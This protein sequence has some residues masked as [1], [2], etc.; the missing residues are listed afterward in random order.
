MTTTEKEAAAVVTSY[1]P[2]ILWLPALRA[3]FKINLIVLA[4]QITDKTSMQDLRSK[5]T[6]N[7]HIAGIFDTLLNPNE[8]LFFAYNYLQRYGAGT[9]K[10]IVTQ[11]DHPNRMNRWYINAL[12]GEINKLKDLGVITYH[13]LEFRPIRGIL[14][15]AP[16][17]TEAQI[18]AAKTKALEL[19]I[20]PEERIEEKTHQELEPKRRVM[21]GLKEYSKD[22]KQVARIQQVQRYDCTVCKFS[23]HAVKMPD[24]CS[25]CRNR[26]HG[27][28][29]LVPADQDVPLRSSMIKNKE[30]S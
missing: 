14:Y 22:L 18:L 7:K 29:V 9:T 24:I 21:R 3:A 25:Q 12:R 6:E 11:M 1:S 16:F 30:E 17:A 15:I 13:V 28:F 10:Q 19:I 5:V 4:E 8:R 23:F 2:D 20:L 27:A 26:G